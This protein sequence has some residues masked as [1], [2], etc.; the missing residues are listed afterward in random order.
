[1]PS[2]QAFWVHLEG[3]VGGTLARASRAGHLGPGKR[4]RE[5]KTAYRR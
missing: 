4:S 5:V 1:M 3:L 2:R